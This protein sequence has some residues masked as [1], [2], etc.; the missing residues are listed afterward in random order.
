MY[1]IPGPVGRTRFEPGGVITSTVSAS[2]RLRKP[3][4]CCALPTI[5][6]SS[7]G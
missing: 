2:A 5:D 4:L 7:H 3:E 1:L 6:V